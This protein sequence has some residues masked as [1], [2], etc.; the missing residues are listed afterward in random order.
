LL[1]KIFLTYKTEILIVHA[2]TRNVLSN[3]DFPVFAVIGYACNEG[4]VRLWEAAADGEKQNVREL[5]D[6]VPLVNLHLK[7]MFQVKNE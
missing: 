1:T 3:A 5:F 6:K 2:S 4:T 7:L